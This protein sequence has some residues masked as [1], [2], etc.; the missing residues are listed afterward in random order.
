MYYLKRKLD[1]I[2]LNFTLKQKLGLSFGV[3]IFFL[4]ILFSIIVS[5]SVRTKVEEDQHFLLS[6]IGNEL[7]NTF[8]RLMYRRSTDIRNMSVLSEF[9]GN[10][11]NKDERRFLLEILQKSYDS[12]A[13]IGF[14]DKNG[15]VQVS[16]KGL[17]EGENV[18]QRSW[19]IAGLKGSFVGDVHEAKLLANKLPP[20]ANGEPLRFLDIAHPVYNNNNQLIGVLGAH[21]SWQWIEETSQTLM[22][23]IP[24]D[25]QI[26]IWILDKNGKIIFDSQEKL[27]GEN[28][29][30]YIPLIE[31]NQSLSVSKKRNFQGVEYLI[32]H[33]QDK[34]HLS[35]EGLG[36]HIMVRQP[37]AI[38]FKSADDLQRTIVILVLATIFSWI[39]WKIAEKITKPLLNIAYEADQIRK[40]NRD[41]SL[42]QFSENSEFYQGKNE[43]LLLS[44]SI[45]DLVQNLI[46]KENKLTKINQELENKIL[47]RTEELNIAKEIAEKANK[48]KSVFLS[49]MSHEL[50]TPLNAIL[51]FSQLMK[52]DDTLTLE[53]K[54][55]LNIIINSGEHLLSLINEV[56]ELSKIEAGQIIFNETTFNREHPILAKDK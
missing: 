25:K 54:E 4:S 44:S 29:R 8:D 33:H 38:A 3:T 14:V 37:T 30:N 18:S 1:K 22:S 17:L 10:G 16:T 31:L 7:V 43:I 5:H 21:L 9:R 36:W 47:E 42:S 11:E 51:G 23:N 55:N 35:Y 46:S 52:D 32:S 26:D 13:W 40:G 50:R 27:E 24:N 19:F 28:I 41:V 6:Q 56:L 39:A 49:N 45:S 15:I 53:N 34:G 12:Y 48:A 20:L 2:F